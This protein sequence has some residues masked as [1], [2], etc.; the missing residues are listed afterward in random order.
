MLDIVGAVL[1][2]SY[3]GRSIVAGYAVHRPGHLPGTVFQGI[4]E[5][6]SHICVVLEF[7]SVRRSTA[8]LDFS[9]RRKS[10]VPPF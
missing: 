7:Q 5:I 8:I 4:S 9:A 2:R 3:T 1:R 6:Q 10:V